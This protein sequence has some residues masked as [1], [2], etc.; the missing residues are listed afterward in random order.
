LLFQFFILHISPFF[1]PSAQMGPNMGILKTS[2]I[3]DTYW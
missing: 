1:G 2:P 3:K